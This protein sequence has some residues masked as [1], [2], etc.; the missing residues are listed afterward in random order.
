MCVHPRCGPLAQRIF[1][2]PDIS[3]LLAFGKALGRCASKPHGQTTE[4]IFAHHAHS[5][6]G[7]S[8]CFRR[9]LNRV[10]ALSCRERTATF[11]Q[12]KHRRLRAEAPVRGVRQ[13]SN[14]RAKGARKRDLSV[15]RP[16]SVDDPTHELSRLGAKGGRG[17]FDSIKGG[18]ITLQ[19]HVRESQVGWH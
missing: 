17:T 11:E 15:G 12:A 16:L 9:G 18:K 14:E 2:D 4:V 5:L 7:G 13:A 6:T 1:R 10:G 8:L 19:T 3:R